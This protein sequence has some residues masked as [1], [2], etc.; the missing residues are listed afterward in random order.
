M[1]ETCQLSEKE[2]KIINDP[3]DPLY[4]VFPNL[5]DAKTPETLAILKECADKNYPVAQ[6]YYAGYLSENANTIPQ[7]QALYDKVIDSPWANITLKKSA[8]ALKSFSIKTETEKKAYF[9]QLADTVGDLLK[10]LGTNENSNAKQFVMPFESPQTKPT[11]VKKTMMFM[12]T[13]YEELPVLSLNTHLSDP[14]KKTIGNENSEFNKR[15][16]NLQAETVTL[17]ADKG[18]PGAQLEMATRLYRQGKINAAKIRIEECATNPF[19][20]KQMVNTALDLFNAQRV[21]PP[22]N[23]G[24]ER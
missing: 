24:H 4:H 23:N 13:P 9:E 5:R 17:L 10:A 12:S 6:Y 18:Y 14:L 8:R 7:S 16:S 21:K 2:K 19:A 3:A 22:K 20:S 1:D 15:M 11:S